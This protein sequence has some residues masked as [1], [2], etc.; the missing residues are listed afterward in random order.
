MKQAVADLRKVARDKGL[1][2]CGMNRWGKPMFHDSEVAA[3]AWSIQQILCR[4]GFL[5]IDGLQ[6]PV[7]ELVRR[8][9]H[10]MTHGHPWQ[11]PA[12]EAD[13]AKGTAPPAQIGDAAAAAGHCP[14]CRSEPVMMDGCSTCTGCGWSKCG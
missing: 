11:P 14:E 8:Y 13:V 5:D 1:V 4:R 2:R 6:V 7:D 3:I 9:A 12:H 10:R